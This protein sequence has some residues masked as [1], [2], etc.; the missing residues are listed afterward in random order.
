MGGKEGRDAIAP[1]CIR[2]TSAPMAHKGRG[3]H[4]SGRRRQTVPGS[5]RRREDFVTRHNHTVRRAICASAQHGFVGQVWSGRGVGIRPTRCPLRPSV[6][7]AKPE[8]RVQGGRVADA[9]IA[10]WSMA[11]SRVAPSTASPAWVNRHVHVQAF[12]TRDGKRPSTG[13]DANVPAAG[14][15]HWASSY[16]V[17]KYRSV[18]PL[19]CVVTTP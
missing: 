7:R 8:E 10:A 1:R 19:P 6:R 5:R 2:V 9:M 14:A 4:V 12:L 13:Q 17:T 16:G 15:A 18:F 11:C 3:R